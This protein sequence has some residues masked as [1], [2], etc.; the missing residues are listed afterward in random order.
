MDTSSNGQRSGTGSR[1]AV[2]K[3]QSRLPASVLF[4]LGSR[5]SIREIAVKKGVGTPV[6]QLKG[7]NKRFDKVV[8]VEKMDLDIEEGS[9][10]SLLGPSGCGK[11]TILRMIP[12]LKRPQRVIYSSR[13]SGSMIYLSTNEN[14]E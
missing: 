1:Q 12:A 10:V 9:L 4:M 5:R 11:T 2:K 6:V 13:A 14:W 3:K 7:V 8:A